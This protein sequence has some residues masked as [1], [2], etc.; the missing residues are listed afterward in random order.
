MAADELI[1]IFH[2]TD[3]GVLPLAEMALREAGVEYTVR[4]LGMDIRRAYTVAV[5]DFNNP[6]DPAEVLVH[7]NDARRARELLA[8]L[9][10]PNATVPAETDLPHG[11]EGSRDA[12]APAEADVPAQVEDDLDVPVEVVQHVLPDDARIALMDAESGV[13]LGTISGAQLKVLIDR[14]EEESETSQRY[15]IDGPTLDMLTDQGTDAALID[16]LRRALGGRDGVEIRWQ[17]Q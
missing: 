12:G 1:S 2:T 16:V 4:R 8:D 10:G 11:V 13:S 14:L 5:T 15:Y 7:P 3:A 6:L 9:A 17:A